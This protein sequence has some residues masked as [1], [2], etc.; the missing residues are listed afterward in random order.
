[1]DKPAV[2]QVLPSLVTGG[3]E[4]GTIEMVAALKAAGWKPYVASAGGPMAKEVAR[5]GG[6]HI[7]L[8]LD[9]KDPRVMWKNIEKLS[10]IIDAYDIKIIHARS[11][12][13]A[14]S[15]WRA[16]HR[17]GQHFV[18]T[19]HN[20]Y[21]HETALKRF[22]NSVMA[23]GERVIAISKFVADHAKKTYKI[24]D[25]RLRTIP[26]G[27]DTNR[28]NRAGIDAARADALRAEWGLKPDQPVVIMPGRLT[29][30]KGQLDFIAAVAQV[31]RR[32][33]ACI[34]VGSGSDGYKKEL[35]AAIETHQLQGVVRVVDE[36]RDMPAAFYISDIMVSASTR[37]EGFGRV[38]VEAQAM[39]CMV[40]ATQ[41]G[42]AEETVKNGETGWLVPPGNIAKMAE[43]LEA[44]LALPRD[45]RVAYGK[46]AIEA[47]QADYTTALMTERTLAVYDELISA[48]EMAKH[49]SGNEDDEAAKK[50]KVKPK[51]PDRYLIIRMGAL[52]DLIMCRKAFSDIRQAHP[53]AEIGLL[54]SPAYE[55]FAKAM[56]WFNKIITAERAAWWKLNAW[57]A[58]LAKLYNFGPL[59]VYDLQGK[60]RQS[61]LYMLMGGP[62]FGP[63][64]SGA[65]PGCSHPRLWPPKPG[66][67]FMDFLSAQLRRAAV[68]DAGR[69]DL[70]WL[71]APV[72]EFKLPARY[73]LIIPG[74]SPDQPHK[75]WPAPRY[76][77]IAKRL[78]S[79]GITPI[80][81]GSNAE[82]GVLA[83]IHKL[84]PQSLNLGGKTSLLELASMAEKAAIVVGNDT[85]PMH[86]AAAVGA[87]T[88][89][90]LSGTT[91]PTWT[92]PTSP[93][94][95]WLREDR[96]NNISIDDVSI[97]VDKLLN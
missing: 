22:Y 85:G 63:E 13:P 71:G 53:D 5:A 67:S 56:P 47:V 87:T 41:H 39:G 37:P 2:L 93:R 3:V 21:G 76:A 75:R 28:F 42:G 95:L 86:I 38:I 8:P 50:K 82:A 84:A 51:R 60:F 36:C 17:T 62:F 25:D 83:D 73:A 77:E 45:E 89:F 97:A 59:R 49:R 78:K 20:A 46:R 64:W 23:K 40:I 81:I 27:V 43:A 11:R 96:I 88:V 12:A 68:P 10:Q 61:V 7:T 15:A 69:P 74:S 26:R 79:R 33:I 58:L 1:M 94:N 55:E 4:R 30:W 6:N 19:F 18:T 65:A 54:T 29:R 31:K 44:A 91:N 34:I 70:T 90:I 52:G 80:L 66:M 32:D 16:A 35:Q 72:V 48:D 24:S 92:V 9:S 57:F 14:W